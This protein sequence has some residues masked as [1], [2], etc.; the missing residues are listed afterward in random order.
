MGIR[1]QPRELNQ[2]MKGLGASGGKTIIQ[3]QE[4]VRQL[5][6]VPDG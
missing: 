2:I 6:V 4:R 5:N 3:Q 1:K